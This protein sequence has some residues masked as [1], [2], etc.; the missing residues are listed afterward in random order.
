MGLGKGIGGGCG[1]NGGG[2]GAKRLCALLSTR[3]QLLV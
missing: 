2:D 1:G 3:Q